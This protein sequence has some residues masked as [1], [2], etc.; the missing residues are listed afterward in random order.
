MTCHDDIPFSA[1]NWSSK[2]E[3][4][5]CGGLV[6]LTQNAQQQIRAPE[7]AVTPRNGQMDG[8]LDCR[9][10]VIAPPGKVIRL[11]LTQ[12]DMMDG[13]CSED[14]V[15]VYQIIMILTVSLTI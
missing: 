15:E 10:I 5:G 12:I 1:F 8:E 3:R 4:Q 14:Y 6:N 9:W 7:V 13:G 2:G 11:Q